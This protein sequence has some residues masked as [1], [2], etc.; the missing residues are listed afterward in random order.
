MS[1]TTRIA[2]NTLMLYFRQILIMLVSLYTV[3]VVLETLGAEDYGI[4]NVV[5]GIVMFFS[6]LSGTMASA[7]QRFFSFALGQGDLEK[8]KKTFT[9]NLIVYGSIA[10][11]AFILL[12]TA[13]LWFINERLHIPP[14]RFESAFWV[15]NFSVFTFIAVI[16]TTPFMAIIIAHEDMQIYAYISII[17]AIMKLG[18]VFLLTYL[19]WDKLELYGMLIFAVSVIVFVIYFIICTRKYKEVQFRRFY[20]DKNLLRE[21]TGFTGWTLFGQLT[22]VMR[23]QAVIIL[24]NQMFNPVVVAAKAVAANI[25]GAVNTFAAN[26]N[27]GL[28]P[29][30]IKSYAADDKKEMFLLMFRGSKITFFLMW[31]FALPLFLEMESVL[32]IWLKNPPPAAVLFTRLA[33]IEVLINSISLPLATAARAPGKMR[34]YELTLGTIQIAIFPVSL[35]VLMLGGEASSVFIVAIAANL[36]MFIV[37]LLIVRRL[38]GFSLSPFFLQVIFPVLGV[39]LLSAISAFAIHWILPTGFIFLCVS[40]LLCVLISCGSMFFIGLDK[41]EREKV[42]SVIVNRMKRTAY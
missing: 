40:V 31:V 30:I 14:D 27:V 7:T 16:F 9:V 12:K 18:V 11:V 3:R 5:G 4:Y 41:L 32:Q 17:E 21:I 20:W 35:I 28:Y 42:R 33:L 39:V 38:I 36:V 26:F 24:L 2:K 8:L 1:N 22:T 19:P 34:T 29:P 23:N 10:V 25:T 37:R 13:G 15:F 6:F